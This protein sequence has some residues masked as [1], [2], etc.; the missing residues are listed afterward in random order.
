MTL[1]VWHLTAMALTIGLILLI[2]PALLAVAPGSAWWWIS[3]PAW[4]G[5]LALA[6]LPFIAR[7]RR[8]EAGSRAQQ[9]GSEASRAA[10]FA[11]TV[12]VCVSFGSV[13][14]RGLT[15]A[16]PVWAA[17]AILPLLLVSRWLVSARRTGCDRELSGR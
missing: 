4:V 7:F 5:I 16:H 15:M 17:V 14:L 6:T 1:Y 2:Q 9:P 3:R 10:A 12:A 11:A 13:A 8:F